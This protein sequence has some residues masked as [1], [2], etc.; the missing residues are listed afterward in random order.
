MNYEANSRFSQFREKHLKMLYCEGKKRDSVFVS[1]TVE[2]GNNMN[3][4]V[5]MFREDV[6]QTAE[7]FR[8]TRN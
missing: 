4:H 3:T 1:R 6:K 2:T 5:T 8:N 7:L